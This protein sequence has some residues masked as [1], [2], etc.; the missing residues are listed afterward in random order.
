MLSRFCFT[1]RVSGLLL[2]ALIGCAGANFAAMCDALLDR[3]PPDEIPP[4]A[5]ALLRGW[6]LDGLIATLRVP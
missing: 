2:L 5:A 6:L 4:R 1:R 3:L